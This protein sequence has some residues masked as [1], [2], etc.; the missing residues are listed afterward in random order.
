MKCFLDYFKESFNLMMSWLV[1]GIEV[2]HTFPILMTFTNFA[3]IK[4]GNSLKN[5]MQMALKPLSPS[6]MTQSPLIMNHL[7]EPKP[8]WLLS[9]SL[10]GKG[11]FFNF[12]VFRFLKDLGQVFFFQGNS[13][14]DCK[15][16]KKETTMTKS[17]KN[18]GKF[19]KRDLTKNYQ[20]VSSKATNPKYRICFKK[21]KLIQMEV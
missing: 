13:Q 9:Q 20:I 1:F 7:Q 5:G 4:T 18:I 8:N 6:C 14:A 21:C 19:T 16:L 17:V 11:T 2:I 10:E 3:K 12:K 15:T